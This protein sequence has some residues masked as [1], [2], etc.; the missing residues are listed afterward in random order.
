M[1]CPRCA[2]R[3][4]APATAPGQPPTQ[5]PRVQR[6]EF[7]IRCGGPGPPTTRRAPFI[8]NA[9]LMMTRGR[10]VIHARARHSR[11]A[12][13]AAVLPAVATCFLLMLGSPLLAI[14]LTM[15]QAL[16]CLIPATLIWLVWFVIFDAIAR[17]NTTIET[18]PKI[19]VAACDKKRGRVSLE[20]D[21]GRWLSFQLLESTP[22]KRAE[23]FSALSA[24]YKRQLARVELPRH[25]PGG[26]ALVIILL[27][28]V[29]MVGVIW[30]I[31]IITRFE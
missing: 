2:A 13:M 27:T 4:T 11:Y 3:L 24:C 10:V 26:I 31:M 7:A 25:P 14:S 6:R 28:L 30:M 17:Q 15:T 29:A 18:A 21:H 20:L 12:G 19:D 1:K 5:R 22:Q 9:V 23:L 8:G 16:I